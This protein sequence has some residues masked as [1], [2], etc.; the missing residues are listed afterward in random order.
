MNDR[1]PADPVGRVESCNG[2]VEGRIVDEDPELLALG[3][4]E[5]RL[6]R[7]TGGQPASPV[8]DQ[9]RTRDVGRRV[10]GQE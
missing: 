6:R 9:D 1:L 5:P 2:I 3:T 7:G 10:T 8:D 4:E